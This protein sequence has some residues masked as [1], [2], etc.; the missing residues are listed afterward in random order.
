MVEPEANFGQAGRSDT[1]L[2]ELVELNQSDIYISE[3]DELSELSDTIL[4]LNE[5]S[6]TEEGAG[7]VAGRNGSFSAHRKI[8][9]KFNLGRFYTKF[10]QAFGDVSE[11]PFAFSDHIQHPAKMIL[12]DL[13]RIKWYQS[14]F[15]WRKEIDE[16]GVLIT[17]FGLINQAEKKREDKEICYISYGLVAI[18]VFDGTKRIINRTVLLCHHQVPDIRDG[19][20]ARIAGPNLVVVLVVVC[21]PLLPQ[22]PPASPIEDWGTAIP[23][24]GRDRAIP[25]RP[26]LC[27]VTSR[28]D[29]STRG[30]VGAGVD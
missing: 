3:L 30:T 29:R 6:D 24:E 11:V 23:I 12:L 16:N 17:K 21:R 25:E 8:H 14:H 4:D 18:N 10:D 20:R 5:L 26:H 2:G 13:G 7:L 9:K 28:E 1:Y 22:M 15:G 19:F 27:G